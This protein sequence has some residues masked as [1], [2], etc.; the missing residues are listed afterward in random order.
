MYSSDSGHLGKRLTANGLTAVVSL[1]YFILQHG[2]WG[3]TI[4]KRALSIR[5]VRADDGGPITYGTAAWRALFTDLI[6]LVTCGVGALVDV[7][8]ILW[9]QRRQALHDKV[10]R[11]VVMKVAGPD[12]YAG[13]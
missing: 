13:R 6:A 3:Q 1:I 8:W 9:D 7:L 12:P 5:V 11:T 2:R 10:A 4:G